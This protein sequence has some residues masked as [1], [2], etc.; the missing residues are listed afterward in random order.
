MLLSSVRLALRATEQLLGVTHGVDKGV[1]VTLIIGVN[2]RFQ[3][4]SESAS[5]VWVG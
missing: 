3:R 1:P 4:V 5:S 2:N